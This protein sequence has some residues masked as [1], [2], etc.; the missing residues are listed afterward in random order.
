MNS[1]LS[2]DEDQSSDDEE[3]EI[4]G[5]NTL[6]LQDLLNILGK[7]T[8]FHKTIPTYEI[9]DSIDNYLSQKSKEE[10]EM[11]KFIKNLCTFVTDVLC[12]KKES[13]ILSTSIYLFDNTEQ[14]TSCIF[15]ND[16]GGYIVN[17]KNSYLPLGTIC[18]PCPSS[19]LNVIDLFDNKT[20]F[21]KMKEGFEQLRSDD[22][23]FFLKQIRKIETECSF[24][25]GRE[26]YIT[27]NSG[28]GLL[29]YVQ[30]IYLSV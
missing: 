7:K 30:P 15:N 26:N 14:P 1:D 17:S 13:N 25:R 23:L 29:F 16:M 8:I 9:D 4:E 3:Y 5:V 22:V 11:N 24:K 19:I 27:L 2:S 20:L 10:Y 21:S 18:L 28:F 12:D 6:N